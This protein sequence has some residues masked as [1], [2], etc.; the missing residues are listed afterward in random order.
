MSENKDEL[1]QRAKLAEQV[2]II[3]F[4]NFL[5]LIFFKIFNKNLFKFRL[6]GTM[7]WLNQ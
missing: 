2:E 1:V 4:L 3:S 7:I 5:L 6:K